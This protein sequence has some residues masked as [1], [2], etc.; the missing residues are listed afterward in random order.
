MTQPVEMQANGIGA[1]LQKRMIE[2]VG[3]GWR[4]G[5]KLLVLKH[6]DKMKYQS[7][8]LDACGSFSKIFSVLQAA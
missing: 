2:R 6:I 1:D 3:L 7:S 5:V 4:G 8:A